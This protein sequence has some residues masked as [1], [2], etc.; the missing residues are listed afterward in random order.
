MFIIVPKK[1]RLE[2]TQNPTK[3]EKKKIR[4]STMEHEQFS[5]KH[6]RDNKSSNNYV[7]MK[8][9]CKANADPLNTQ[10]GIIILVNKKMAERLRKC[11]SS[12][13]KTEHFPEIA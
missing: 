6:T 11:L 12:Q 13:K 4:N 3:E 7:K 2:K 10:K 1:V 9:S 5:K 8:R